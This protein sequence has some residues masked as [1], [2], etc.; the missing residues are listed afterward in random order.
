MVND[1]GTMTGG[2]GKPRGGRM[3]LGNAAPKQAADARL[4][5]AELAVAEKQEA[6]SLEVDQRCMSLISIVSA[7]C[8]LA[9]S[10]GCGGRKLRR[11]LG[12]RHMA[13]QLSCCLLGT[14]DC[15][16]AG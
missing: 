15:A 14:G 1:S 13:D 9:I 4:Q 12:Y 7:I 8:V 6:V 16:A 11:C 5:A 3:R 2:G 10:A